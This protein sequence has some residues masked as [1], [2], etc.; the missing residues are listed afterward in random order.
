MSH[1]TTTADQLRG[2]ALVGAVAAAGY[3]PSILNTQPWRW[4]LQPGQLQL[5]AERSRQL[6]VTDPQG[7]QLTISCGAALDH[8]GTALAAAGWAAHVTRLPDPRQP[9]L[10]ATLTV[11]EPI[12]ATE[13][14]ARLAEAIPARHTDRRPVS[15]ELLPAAALDAIAAVA[16]THSRLHIFTPDQ[17]LA[18]ASAVGRAAAV[19]ADDHRVA[20]ELAHWTG[21][22]APPGTGLPA[23]VLPEHPAQTTV[24]GRDFGRRGTLPI[25]TGHDK[26][27]V[28]ALLFGD[29][30]EP[31]HWLRTGEALS[32]AWLTATA[33][34]VSVVPLS[35]VIE[36]I[37]TRLTL[38]RLI[39]GLG[40]PHLVLRLGVADPEHAE[41]IQT[42]RLA[43]TPIP[44]D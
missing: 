25:G 5:F 31:V 22:A 8:A 42:P 4:H 3:A 10:L 41:H 35:H 7:R 16:R 19:Q 17:A 27:A 38:R 18:L 15:D 30:D 20:A 40:S 33:L 34:G 21:T 32:A 29:A 43:G 36:V 2:D 37:R 28:Y 13:V 6:T 24:P 26:T 11:V 44:A 39:N 9:D 14:A 1:A 12:T 23:A